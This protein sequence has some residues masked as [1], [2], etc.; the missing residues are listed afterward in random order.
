MKKL[1]VKVICHFKHL[2]RLKLSS[3]KFCHYW[4]FKGTGLSCCISHLVV[5]HPHQWTFHL[6]GINSSPPIYCGP[7][8]GQ[9]LYSRES[10]PGQ[11]NDTNIYCF[12]SST[13]VNKITHLHRVTPK[14]V[15]VEPNHLIFLTE[16][17]KLSSLSP[18]K[19]NLKQKQTQAEYSACCPIKEMIEGY[20]ITAIF[21]L[22][23]KIPRKET[24]CNDNCVY[25]KVNH[26]WHLTTWPF[27]F[28]YN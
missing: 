27:N 2:V 19:Q 20:Y 7:S 1:K 5:H 14:L 11:D 4:Y 17:K 22:K 3:E 24:Y 28:L 12:S 13:C 15:K 8:Q 26:Y 21:V 9:C 23:Y 18:V 16:D 6:V 10:R 25:T